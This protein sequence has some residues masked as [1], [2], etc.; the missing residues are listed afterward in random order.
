[1]PDVFPEI[2]FLAPNDGIDD[3]LQLASKLEQQ[4]ISNQIYWVRTIASFTRS[5]RLT[6][7]YG[8]LVYPVHSAIGDPLTLP[9]EAGIAPGQPPLSVRIVDAP[10]GSTG[11]DVQVWDDV[12]DKAYA[13]RPGI[14]FLDWDNGSGGKVVTEVFAGFP[15]TSHYRH[16]ANS[17]PE[18]TPPVDLDPLSDDLLFFQGLKYQ[19]GNATVVEKQYTASGAGKAVLLFSLNRP[20]PTNRQL[21]ILTKERLKVRVVE[22]RVWNELTELGGMP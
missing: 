18:V 1:M 13:L 12:V 11:N 22:T 3:T 10:A 19:T 4:T 14:F 2:E 5:T 20:I 6:W 7:D 9:A 8:D 21:A 15:D 17:P 16:I